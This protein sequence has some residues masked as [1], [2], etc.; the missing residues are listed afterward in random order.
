MGKE[1]CSLAI[2]KENTARIVTNGGLHKCS[3]DGNSLLEIRDDQIH[4]GCIGIGT[5]Y[6]DTEFTNVSIRF[7]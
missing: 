2:G 6:C 7:H 3:M 5:K 1:S 4:S